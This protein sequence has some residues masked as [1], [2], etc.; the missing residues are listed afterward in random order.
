MTDRWAQSTPA[1]RA[2]RWREP[3]RRRQAPGDLHR[4]G[5]RHE[6]DVITTQ[7]LFTYQFEHLIADGQGSFTP[8]MLLPH[9]LPK[10]E[11]VRLDNRVIRCQLSGIRSHERPQ[12]VRS[13]PALKSGAINR[14]FSGIFTAMIAWVVG[15]PCFCS[16]L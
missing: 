1:V 7:D 15:C 3:P 10:A 5:D 13:S 2:R 16:P 11:Y 12:P 8:S 6:G 4:G 9:F 14:L